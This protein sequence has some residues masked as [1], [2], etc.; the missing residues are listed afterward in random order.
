MMQ[1][2]RSGVAS[3]DANRV[4][5]RAAAYSSVPFYICCASHN[6]TRR[7]AR[8]QRAWQRKRVSQNDLQRKPNSHSLVPSQEQRVIDIMQV[9]VH[10]CSPRGSK[11]VRVMHRRFACLP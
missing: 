7:K 8:V 5:W 9:R 3:L 11:S 4:G 6:C 1:L 2:Q 10:P